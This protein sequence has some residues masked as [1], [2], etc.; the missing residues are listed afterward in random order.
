MQSMTTATAT[1]QFELMVSA[2][3]EQAAPADVLPQAD[4]PTFTMLAVFDGERWASLCREV[5]ISSDGETAEAAFE[6][7]VQAINEAVAAAAEKGI[8]PGA[9]VPD[10]ALWQFME[11]H[12]GSDAMAVRI[13]SRQLLL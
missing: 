4:L 7:L 13:L 12:Q 10:E 8:E 2:P 9:P 3:P 1:E 11:S 6:N 5:D